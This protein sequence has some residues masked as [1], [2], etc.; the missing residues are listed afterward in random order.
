MCPVY[1][2]QYAVYN[3]QCALS[4]AECKVC[5][6]VSSVKFPVLTVQCICQCSHCCTVYSVLCTSRSEQAPGSEFH[7]RDK[8]ERID[9]GFLGPSWYNKKVNLGTYVPCGSYELL[10]SNVAHQMKERLTIQNKFSHF[11]VNFY[12][13]LKFV[14]FSVAPN[15][16]KKTVWKEIVNCISY[17]GCLAH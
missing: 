5:S 12:W 2:V 13:N 3:M 11:E 10:L 14:P 9:C 17:L 15:H 4:S 1:T 6:S 16:Q 8:S 7:P